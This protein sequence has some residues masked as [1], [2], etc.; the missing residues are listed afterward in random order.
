[1]SVANILNPATGQ[2]RPEYIAGGGGGITS[3]NAETGP[4]ITISAGA[5]ITVNT[6][7]NN[8]QIVNTG[9]G[10][11]ITSINTET[12]PA[13][14]LTGS[15]GITIT[16]PAPNTIDIA[17]GGGGAFLPLAGGTMN[18]L[19]AG[20]ISAH[21]IEDI[22][23]LE[24]TPAGS[25]LDTLILTNAGNDL[26]LQTGSTDGLNIDTGQFTVD[27][28]IRT[29][30][31]CITTVQPI[32]GYGYP[33]AVETGL[34]VQNFTNPSGVNIQR[35]IVA[36][37]ITCPLTAI[38]V[39]TNN[40]LT[41]IGL[42]TGILANNT[43]GQTADGI[44]ANTITA[45]AEANGVK[46][47]SVQSSNTNAYGVNIDAVAGA[48]SATGVEITTVSSSAGVASGVVVD[49]VSATGVGQ[50]ARG[51]SVNNVSCAGNCVGVESRILNSSAQT[52]TGF[53]ATTLSA[54][55]QTF[56][57]RFS[58][59]GAVL[60]ISDAFG[61]DLANVRQDRTAATSRGRGVNMT[62][63]EGYEATGV[64]VETVY[65][66]NDA[67]GIRITDV[68]A[69]NVARPAYGLIAD[70]GTKLNTSAGQLMRLLDGNLG[71]SVQYLNNAAPPN[72]ILPDAGNLVILG[73]AVPAGGLLQLVA[74]PGGWENGAWFLICK[75]NPI[76][77]NI[78]DTGLYP[79][80]GVVP[81]GAFPF[82]AGAAYD[83]C[84]LFFS[85]AGGGWFAN[86]F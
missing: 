20:V 55:G 11:G 28:A 49:G 48:N 2:I 62:S 42:A 75:Q 68:K 29:E 23:T 53:S 59:I 80:N 86:A 76:I 16:N 14:T 84:L 77:I 64:N 78:Q 70:R 18:P 38:G 45:A 30:L 5:G 47:Q 81:P 52:T 41:T 32:G 43:N 37:N 61:L 66:N 31:N 50:D 15:S 4:A 71:L 3:I 6:T 19:P 36:D 39:A 34:L 69:D 79:I 26:N 73:P 17:G 85:V 56:G 51:V 54:A 22:I 60:G 21:T 8:I 35:G 74:P 24:G 44:R 72:Q 83:M 10:G 13:I 58:G 12:G 33:A 67:R 1:M 82:P 7:P 57:A 27:A 63:V 25:G 40:V 65:G 9:G 46:V